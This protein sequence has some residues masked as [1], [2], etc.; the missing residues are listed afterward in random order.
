MDPSIVETLARL[1]AFPTV[2]RR[3]NL[4]L[5][6]YV[7][8]LVVPAGVRVE[9]FA[10]DDGSRANLWATVGPD[11][12]GGVVLSAHSDVVP[13]EGQAWTSG[14]FALRQEG[15]RLY[16]RGTADMKG[17]VAVAVHALI[18]AASAPLQRPLH[19]ALSCDEEVGCLGVRPMIEALARRADRPVFC[20]IGEPTG[21][22]IASGHKG[23]MA[24]R[25]CCHGREGHSALAPHALNALHLGAAFVQRLQERQNEIAATGRRDE[26]YDIPYTTLHAG[27]FTGGTALNIVPNFSCVEFE[28]RPIAADDPEAIVRDLEADAAAITAPI[29][30]RFPEARI[31]IERLSGYPGLVTPDD[32]APIAVLRRLLGEAGPPIKVAFG[33]EGGLFQQGLGIPAVICG[34][35]HMEQGH[36]PDEFITLPQLG[37]CDRLLRALVDEMAQEAP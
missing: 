33:T 26:A 20:L 14:P 9:R 18:R 29:V 12:P 24:Y 31:E 6:A 35:G 15:D 11:G 28:I 16:G 19:L 4:D 36:K 34:P 17:F 30:D 23:K 8:A 13:V 37:R 2:S 5:L 21:M 25:A 32:S 3:P 10:Y 22:R 7:E 27:V 1:V